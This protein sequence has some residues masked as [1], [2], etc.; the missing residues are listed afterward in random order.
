MEF[1]EKPIATSGKT[2]STGIYVIRRRLLIELIQKAYDEDRYDFVK[3]IVIRYM[4]VKK[5]YG[6]RLDSYWSNISTVESYFKTNMDFLNRDIRKH[7][8]KDSTDIY[9]KTEDLAPAKYNPGSEVKNCI[10]ASG[11]IFNGKV[12]DSVIFKKVY[13]GSN[14]Y[15]KN[16]IILNDVHIGDNCHLENCIIESRDT[17]RPNTEYIGQNGEIKIAIE[18]NERFPM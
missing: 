15:I 11:C 9:S 12:E 13:V 6:Y 16:C 4:N 8:F 14:T 2:V 10:V 17:I 7:F 3:D 1:E 18:K 5:I